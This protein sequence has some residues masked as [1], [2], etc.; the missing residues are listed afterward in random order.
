MRII[1]CGGRTYNN[2]ELVEMVVAGLPHDTVVIEG[3]AKG[4]DTLAHDAALALGMVGETFYANWT[5]FGKPAGRLR[6]QD[7]L[8]AGADYVIAFGGHTGTAHMVHIAEQAG[9]P[10][11]RP[12]TEAIPE[13]LDNAVRV[14]WNYA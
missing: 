6:N 10:V 2:G 11:W 3:G 12:D 13:D 1:I 7:M 14:H 5:K 8:D 9:V 4:A